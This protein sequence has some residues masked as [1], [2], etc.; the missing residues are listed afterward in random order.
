[1]MKI[2]DTPQSREQKEIDKLSMAEL[3]RQIG[4]Q[5]TMIEC[6]SIIPNE[7]YKNAIITKAKAYR[8]LLWTRHDFLESCTPRE[9]GEHI[10][11][12]QKA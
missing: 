9:G 1:M 12:S 10:G 11:G 3:K 2:E 8:K 5:N 7:H 4:N 6:A